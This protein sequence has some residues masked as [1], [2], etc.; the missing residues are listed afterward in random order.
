MVA[1]LKIVHYRRLRS[2]NTTAYRLAQQS[3]TEWTVVVADAQT[4][5]RGR[6]GR[7]WKSPKGGLW[8]SILLRP[9]VPSPKL[10]LL[11][12]LAAV[13]TRQALEDETGLSVK[14]KW[15]NDL[16]LGNAKL[17]GI[18]IESKTL[19]DRISFAIL[20]IGLNIN[21]SKAQLPPEAISLR[22][23]SGKQHDLRLLLR[24]ILDQMRS[25][26]DDLDNPSKIMEDWWRN[27]VHRPLRVQVTVSK[28]AVTGVSRAI[29][30]DGSLVIET[31]DHKIR[32][33][34]EGSLTILAD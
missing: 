32:R 17:G 29:D 19:A 16:V 6:R 14:L 21:Q 22:L 26:Y 13:A 10:P 31:D 9:N 5:G 8:F 2:T 1:S 27:C 33:V 24:A 23:V 34:S 4:K 18:L 3:A 30:E 12:F 11:Q 28:D 25:S 7:R 20:G 15:P